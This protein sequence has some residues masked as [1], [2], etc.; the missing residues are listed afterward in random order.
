MFE[1]V[2]RNNRVE[3]LPESQ[4]AIWEAMSIN[5]HIVISKVR[6]GLFVIV[7]V[8]ARVDAVREK[9]LYKIRWVITTADIQDFALR[10]QFIQEINF[11]MRPKY[12]GEAW[13]DAQAK[14]TRRSVLWLFELRFGNCE[15]LGLSHCE[16][17]FW[18]P[19]PHR[20]GSEQELELN[21]AERRVSPPRQRLR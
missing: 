17:L 13:P 1:V 5:N 18:V 16:P 20:F 7:Y 14:K 9:R 19:T 6:F 4:Y 2:R 10:R 12:R 15:A 3:F 21:H 11:P 8:N